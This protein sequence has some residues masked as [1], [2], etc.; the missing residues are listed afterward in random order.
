MLH[1][2]LAPIQGKAKVRQSKRNQQCHDEEKSSWS[3]TR[4]RV[5]IGE[6]STQA[7]QL[8]KSQDEIQT[9][10][11]SLDARLRKLNQDLSEIP[12]IVAAAKEIS[13]EVRTELCALS[14]LGRL[15]NTNQRYW[16]VA[17]AES[18]TFHWILRDE[19]EGSLPAHE[20]RQSDPRDGRNGIPERVDQKPGYEYIKKDVNIKLRRWLRDGSGLFHISGKPGSGKS[21]LMKYLVRH[22]EVKQLLEEWAKPKRL[23]LGKFFFWKPGHG[24]NTL[25]ALIRGLIH[26]MIHFDASLVHSAFPYCSRASFEQLSLQ[27]KIEMT[28]EDVWEAFKTLIRDGN[29]S[30]MLNFCFFIDGLDELDEE[31][32]TTHSEIVKILQQWAGASNGFVKI[33][34]SSRHF[35]V[36]ENMAVDHRVRLQ[37]LT[38]SDIIDFV[39][40]TLG[41]NQ[42][43]RSEMTVND[44]DC[45]NLINSIV[46]EAD[47]VFLWVSLVVKSVER[48]LS[49]ADSIAVLRERVKGTPK[50]LE[51]LF[52]SLLESIEDCH[53][54]MAILLLAIT[55][56]WPVAFGRE[57]RLIVTLSISECRNFF[58]AMEKT[59]NGDIDTVFRADQYPE[60]PELTPDVVKST[61]SKVFFRCKGLFEAVS[62]QPAEPHEKYIGGR[63]KFLHRSIPE[64]LERWIPEQMSAHGLSSMHVQNALCWMLWAEIDLLN[65]AI[66]IQHLSAVDQ[67]SVRSYAYACVSTALRI[68]ETDTT[69]KFDLSNALQLL[70]RAEI[71]L[72]P[73][74][75][76]DAGHEENDGNL[77]HRTWNTIKPTPAD[78]SALFQWCPLFVT[79]MMVAAATGCH[80]YVCWK[81][82]RISPSALFDN[83]IKHCLQLAFDQLSYRFWRDTEQFHN[84]V[85][86]IVEALIQ[87]D[88]LC[89]DVNRTVLSCCGRLSRFSGDTSDLPSIFDA[90]WIKHFCVA[91]NSSTEQ[92][93]YIFGIIEFL[94]GLGAV[95]R[96]VVCVGT[97]RDWLKFTSHP[98]DGP[99]RPG[100]TLGNVEQISGAVYEDVTFEAADEWLRTVSGQNGC[101]VTLEKWVTYAKP[102]N[103]AA[104]LSLIEHNSRTIG[105]ISTDSRELT[106]TER[107]RT[108]VLERHG[109][110]RD[111]KLVWIIQKE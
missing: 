63:V 38:K 9:A 81:L 28:K 20:E 34:V 91:E 57:G 64:F 43:F 89:A 103:M 72:L 2:S 14:V 50:K 11:T 90:M 96:S 82:A 67:Q 104:V 110:H 86:I 56:S 19:N 22:P 51:E 102:P 55:M 18:H 6:I 70:D 25:E 52:K 61:K 7:D 69:L 17:E 35:P 97:A 83:Y 21:T 39:R 8:R 10:L 107:L 33:C 87:K 15:G 36:F 80:V 23:A 40:N 74:S 41:S 1:A 31:M 111:H 54:Q 24:Q 99:D 5:Q 84:R 108:A 4:H 30:K 94:L 59:K 60:N 26:S 58:Q 49:N 68:L 65:S 95:P 73:T 71:I 27:S 44:E 12:K 93:R 3:L 66:K 32:D 47:G 29:S 77:E 109:L 78:H 85:Q 76:L 45:R 105:A 98:H 37:D 42:E 46:D 48:G 92:Q 75:S 101:V 88:G 53:A 62:D 100:N 13:E 79:P 16:D 106:S